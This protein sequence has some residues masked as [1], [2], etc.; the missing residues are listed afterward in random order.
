MKCPVTNRS[1]CGAFMRAS[2]ARI[3]LGREEGRPIAILPRGDSRGKSLRPSDDPLRP[4]LS[5]FPAGPDG[6]VYRNEGMVQ[7]SPL[8]GDTW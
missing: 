8:A 1:F 3:D 4:W 2:V 7:K 5:R 6:L